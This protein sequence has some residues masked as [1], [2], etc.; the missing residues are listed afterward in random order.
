M[1]HSVDEIKVYK[2]TQEEQANIARGLF[3]SKRNILYVKKLGRGEYETY[4]PYCNTYEQVDSKQLAEIR[5]SHICPKCFTSF[6]KTSLKTEDT[7]IDYV[8][9]EKTYG[10]KAKVKWEFGG[11]PK[12]EELTQRLYFFSDEEKT[13]YSSYYGMSLPTFV[14]ALALS[15]MG[16]SLIEQGEDYNYWRYTTSPNYYGNCYSYENMVGEMLGIKTKTKKEYLQ[17]TISKLG[18]KS[19]Q[20]EICKKHLLNPQ[21]MYLIRAFDLKSYEETKEYYELAKKQD[22][23]RYSYYG[24]LLSSDDLLTMKPLN[25]YYLSYIIEN[26]ISLGDFIDY[27]EDMKYLGYKLDKP[28]DFHHKHYEISRI[29]AQA[30]DKEFKKNATKLIK[31]RCASLPNYKENDIEISAFNSP[32]SIR[33]CAKKLKNC[34]ATYIKQYALGETDLYYLNDGK[35]LKVAIEINNGKLVQAKAVSN[36][37]C[38]TDLFKHIKKFC[39]S[40][41]IKLRSENANAY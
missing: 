11:S 34:I 12:L 9:M 18:F 32:E 31:Q 7:V 4:C 37:T 17:D 38:P 15:F 1:K 27:E 40:N 22:V 14:N 41:N 3:F 23:H 33:E 10:Y 6:S 16:K 13:N 21:Q 28:K 36:S 8:V 29:V 20:I 25:K 30:K 26:G 2:P 24:S 19:N 35:E 5:N 39:E